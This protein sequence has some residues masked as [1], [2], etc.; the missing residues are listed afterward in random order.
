MFVRVP[1]KIGKWN[2]VLEI[3]LL[4]NFLS[5]ENQ[6]FPSSKQNSC[7]CVLAR[8]MQGHIAVN[9]FYFSLNETFEH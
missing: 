6:C 3:D 2:R 4:N 9:S 8:K 1:V 5:P 7:Y